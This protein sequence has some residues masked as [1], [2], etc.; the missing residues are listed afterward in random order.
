MLAD[1]TALPE[2]VVRDV[3]T[4]AYDS[5]G[6]RCSAARVLFVNEDI[7][8]R[9]ITMI[10]GAVTALEIGDPMDFATDIGPVIDEEAQD[11]LDA[12]KLSMGRT[13]REIVDCPL[14][15]AC[16]VGSYVT[17]A[18]YEIQ[19]LEALERETFGPVLH[20]IRYAAAR[21]EAV[22]ES[23][24]DMG[25][26]LTLGLHSRLQSSADYLARHARVGN[27]YV[28]RDQVGAVV[29]V[30][31]FGGEG[32]SGTGPKA[33]GPNYLIRFATERTVTTDITATGGNLE[34]LR[35][36]SED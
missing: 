35:R 22:V 34:L 23:I 25:Y 8:D 36:V 19:G 16:R 31:P 26:G 7:A 10:A 17:P 4:S 5:A 32:L 29:G 20:V 13:A 1:S 3:V 21:F 30:Q 14:P 6:Q 11:S 2:Q 27:L 28:N 12:H 9:T 33:G 15:E 18:A 24:N